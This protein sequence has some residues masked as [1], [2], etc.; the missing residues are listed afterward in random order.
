MKSSIYLALSISAALIAGA[1]STTSFM[2]PMVLAAVS[3]NSDG[4]QCQ[5]G[6]GSQGGGTGVHAKIDGSTFTQSGG[7][8]NKIGTG[9]G[10]GGGHTVSTPGQLVHSGGNSDTGGGRSICIDQP[11]GSSVCQTTGKP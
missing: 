11:D 2:N 9:T 1:L 3:C 5:G 6:S 7:G 4:T 8:N 10:G